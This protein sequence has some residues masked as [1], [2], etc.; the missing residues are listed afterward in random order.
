[1]KLVAAHAR[2][3]TLE[4][5]RQPSFSVPTVLFP[6]L[7][8]VFVSSARGETT[9]QLVAS[10]VGFAVLG[11]AF[12]QFGVAIAVERSSPWERF[13]RTL[14]LAAGVR[15]AARLVSAFVFALAAIGLV[16]ATALLTTDTGLGSTGW[17][18]LV[19]TALV[20]SI[21]FALLGIALGY[22]ATPR[23]ALP[24]AN[25]L[26]LTLSFAGGLWTASAPP[27]LVGEIS[28]F[29][30]T[31]EFAEVLWAVPEGGLGPPRSWLVLAG[32]AAVFAVAAEVGYR[33]DEGERYR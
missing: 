7:F 25:L 14:P 18:R 10:F 29:L 28:T 27:G 31:R 19:A 3:G 16:A 30:P 32:W 17:L 23:G 33:R 21:P 1:V 13:V 24:L 8:F 20:A 5:I 15:F 9:P 11:V 6:S 22:W 12:F 4:L 2:A 26:Y